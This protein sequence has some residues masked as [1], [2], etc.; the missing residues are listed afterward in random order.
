GPGWGY[1]ESPLVVGDLL[2][3][4]PGGKQG[5]LVALSKKTGEPVWKSTEVTEGAHYASPVVAE[6]G[7]IKQIVQFARESAFG[8]SLEDGKLLWKY[9]SANNGTANCCDPIIFQ[10]HVFA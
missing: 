2:L 5:T 9:S 10:D 3:V 4:T 7:G 8:V 1:S 6:I